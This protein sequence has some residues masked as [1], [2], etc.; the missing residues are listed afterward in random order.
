MKSLAVGTVGT[1]EWWQARTKF[2]DE[3][4]C[5]LYTGYVRPD[6]YVQVRW[7]DKRTLVHRVAYEIAYGPIPKGMTVCHGCDVTS[8]VNPLHLFL[9]TQKDNMRD[10]FAK[11]RARPRGLPT[12]PLTDFP[13]V[14]RRVNQSLSKALSRE[15]WLSRW[16]NTSSTNY[17]DGALMLYGWRRTVNAPEERLHRAA[18]P[19]KSSPKF[20]RD[21]AAGSTPSRQCGPSSPVVTTSVTDR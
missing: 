6:G 4:G 13:A 1:P 18:R 9:G 20:A 16:H 3:T 11:G 17:A 8:C 7:K 19:Y 15:Q 14:S 10:M 2:D 21:I 5:L 12:V